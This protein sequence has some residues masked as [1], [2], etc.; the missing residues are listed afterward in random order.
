MQ[1]KTNVG[2]GPERL[3]SLVKLTRAG[4]MLCDVYYE[5]ASPDR[6]KVEDLLL[7]HAFLPAGTDSYLWCKRWSQASQTGS[8]LQLR[9]ISHVLAFA[10]LRWAIQISKR[11]PSRLTCQ[12]AILG[13]L[14]HLVYRRSFGVPAPSLR[15][16]LDTPD[17]FRI[18]P[19]P[20][21][22]A[23]DGAERKVER[24]TKPIV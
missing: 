24:A 8:F 18:A 22:M 10:W 3:L 5:L 16:P 12:K 1:K 19:M 20:A 14:G 9:E 11:R 6:Q 15:T 4:I 23:S 21:N 2:R 13:L 17:D 7:E